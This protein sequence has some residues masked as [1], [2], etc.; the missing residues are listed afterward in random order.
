MNFLLRPRIKLVTV[1]KVSK[2]KKPKK[3]FRMPKFV[4]IGN[5]VG[6]VI[7]KILLESIDWEK[8]DTI[9]YMYVDEEKQLVVRN[10]SA[11]QREYNALHKKNFQVWVPYKTACIQSAKIEIERGF[12]L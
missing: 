10:Y 12:L 5:S 3:V 6:L 11:E 1:R 2:K 8:G 9:E 7:S 4:G